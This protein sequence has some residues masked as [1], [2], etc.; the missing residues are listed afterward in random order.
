MRTTLALLAAACITVATSGTVRADAAEIYGKKCATCHGKDG[1]AQTTM[2][3][4]LGVKDLTDAKVQADSKDDK[5][6]K[7]IS[8]GVKDDKGKV[9]MAASKGVT[10]EEVKALVKICRDFKGK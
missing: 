3:K 9:V 10:P 7:S 6:A 4:K 2:G 8:E 1:K 5:W